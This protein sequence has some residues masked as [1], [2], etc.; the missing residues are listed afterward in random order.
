MNIDDMCLSLERHD[1]ATIEVLNKKLQKNLIVAMKK[2][3][4]GKIMVF[5]NARGFFEVATILYN[6]NSRGVYLS[7][8]MVNEDYQQ[9]G[10]GRMI[11]NLAMAHGDKCGKILIYGVADPTDPIKDVSEKGDYNLEVKTIRD[12][13][14][15]LGCT[16]ENENEFK[17]VWNEGEIVASLCEK[18]KELIAQVTEDQIQSGRQ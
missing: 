15:K 8:F 12:I 9:C 11:F 5:D 18:E 13:Y 2:Q 6:I 10:V 17:R 16:I 3:P 4:R 1:F 7:E 14:K